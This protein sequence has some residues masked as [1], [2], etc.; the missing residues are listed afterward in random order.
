MANDAT[1][2]MTFKVREDGSLA[3]AEKQINKAGKAVKDLGNAQVAAGKQA[4]DHYSKQNK[5]VIGTAN[6]TKSF[7]KL[8]QTIG[9]G[10]NGLVGAYAGLAANAFAVSAAF[11]TLNKAA[12][13]ETLMQ[14]LIEQGARAGKTLTVLSGQLKEITNNSI[15]SSEAMQATAQA[16]AAGISG[17]DLKKL[18]TVANEAALAL[19]R[20]VPDSLNRMVLAVTKME[21]ELVDELGLTTKITEASEKYARQLG[22]NV[23]SMSQA[24]KQQALLN[25]WVEQGTLKYGGLADAIDPNP[26]N[27]LAATFDNLVKTGANVINTFLE[28]LISILGSSQAALAGFGLIFLS[29]IK[30]QILPGIQEASKQALKQS[31]EA[32]KISIDALSSQKELSSGKR[33]SIN[34]FINASKE[35]TAS[36]LQFE[37]AIKE[38]N[39]RITNAENRKRPLKP[40]TLNKIKDDEAKRQEELNKVKVESAKS[41][42]LQAQADGYA[43]SEGVNLTNSYSKLKDTVK[44]TG[45]S[46]MVSYQGSKTAETGLKGLANTATSAGKGIAAAGKVAAVGFIN[47]LP[48]IGQIVAALA[49]LWELIGKDIWANLTGRTE[50]VSKALDNFNEVVDSTSKKLKALEAIQ[51][52]T[53]S[54][55]DRSLAAVSN[56]AASIYELADAY[57]ALIQASLERDKQSKREEDS[58]VKQRNLF[59]E[60]AAARRAGNKELVAELQAEQQA[61]NVSS[62]LG[63]GGGSMAAKAFSAQGKE[64]WMDDEYVAAAK[65]LEQLE[66]QLPGV[67]KGFYDMN[68]GVD[69]FNKLDPSIKVR[70]VNEQLKQT[71]KLA[72]DVENA[73]KG[74]D[75]SVN[76]LNTGYVDFIKSISPTTEYDG[77]VNKLQ[78][79]TKSVSESNAAMYAMGKAGGADSMKLQDRLAESIT[80]IEGPA[81][82]MF[83]GGTRE[84]LNYFDTID[85]SLQNARAG[86]QG[87]NKNSDDYKKKQAEITSL[88]AIRKGLLDDNVGTVL[89]EVSAYETL[90]TNAQVEQITRQGTLAIAQANL[91]ALQKQGQITGEDVEKQMKAENAIIELQAQQL[92]TQIII[93]QQDLEREKSALRL[94]ESNQKLLGVYQKQTTEVRT[95]TLATRLQGVQTELESLRG[96]TDSKSASKRAE[97]LSEQTTV[98]NAQIDIDQE[99]NRLLTEQVQLQNSIRVK[100]E[101]INSL[102]KQAEALRMGANTSA[103]RLNAKIKKE[104]ENEK[105]KND[106]LGDTEEINK[107]IFSMQRETV[108]LLAKGTNELSN[109]L[110]NIKDQA[111]TKKEQL[112]GEWS[113]REK[114]LNADLA[115]AKARGNESQIDY[116]ET[117]LEVEGARNVAAIQQVSVE[118]DRNRIQAVA[119]KTIEEEVSLRKKSLEISQKLIEASNQAKQADFDYMSSVVSLERKRSGALDTEANRNMEAIE[120]AQLAYDLAKAEIGIK[121][122]L[123]ELEFQLLE[124][125][126]LQSI[127]DL[128]GRAA[129]LRDKEAALELTESAKRATEPATSTSTGEATPS[130]IVVSATKGLAGS[131]LAGNQ[132]KLLEETANKLEGIGG[133]AIENAGAEAVQALELQLRTLAN[134]LEEA[135]IP[136]PRVKEG[137]VSQFQATQDLIAQFRTRAAKA[138]VLAA[139]DNPKDDIPDPSKVALA[140]DMIKGHLDSMR[141]SFKA[142]GPGGEVI[143]AVMDSAVNISNSFQ[144]AFKVL[145]DAGSSAGERVA[146]VAQAISSIVSGIQSITTAASNAR[147]A[148]IDKEI[149]AE[150][151]RDGKSAASLAKLEA[152]EKKKDGIARKQFNLNKKLMIAQ[153]VMSTAAGVAGALAASAYLTPMGAAIMAGVIGAMGAAQ[154]ALIAGTTYESAYSPKAVG[155][156]SN[157]SIGKRSDTVDLAKGPN[158]NAGGESG[159]LRGSRGTGSNASNYRTIGSAYGGELMRGYGNRGFVVGEKGPEVI[160]PETPIT[161]TPANDVGQA[162]SINASFNIQALDS[163]GVQDILVAQKGNIIKMIREAANNSGQSFLEGVNTNIYTRPQ[164]GKL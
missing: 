143:I 74:L 88:T 152:L 155:T 104:Y 5:G 93:L 149:E 42:I 162:Q 50:E 120:A 40:E 54:A 153:A 148:G 159:Y 98:K 105:Q 15:S 34:E 52:S 67:A 1:F 158:A 137:I 66:N 45:N 151:K 132:A 6:S 87:L 103:E 138:Q 106:I 25:A 99:A 100:Q 79:F 127:T 122:A 117:L 36:Q 68:G 9:D 145:G 131:E 77:I 13:A 63:V 48:V 108:N 116:Y 37:A 44:A 112:K 59:Q 125:Q 18:T 114:I 38:S 72:R 96:K 28:P 110:R 32:R 84:I 75:Q 156:P 115:L 95:Q 107:N 7:S 22:I 24:Q 17:D 128:R 119:I 129:V 33:K 70:L 150:S 35:G 154:I 124:A 65:A 141:E 130:D 123:I 157:L 86:L 11:N 126:R 60:M 135:L 3:L 62:R 163:N 160:T 41:T 2:T 21:P 161:V 19:G 111:E 90:V 76:S 57:D 92:E 89:K 121:T 12:Q 82:N 4:D 146:A 94:I 20:N 118:E 142:L 81:R 139:N 8:S 69:E 101:G 78:S 30:G 83:T 140:T 49:I 61:L 14:G 64:L 23:T 144:D 43:A 56:Q 85:S 73:F 58:A 91:K 46:Y 80:G 55:S 164:V 147:I 47:F 27:K 10:N 71:G 133:T 39:D 26:Y 29:S 113:F 102:R 97:L 53:A 109:Q 16:T 51:N 136:G 134:K 31:E